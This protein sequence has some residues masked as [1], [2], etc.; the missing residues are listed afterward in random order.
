MQ[1]KFNLKKQIRKNHRAFT[2]LELTVVVVVLA[3]LVGISLPQYRKVV[4]RGRFAEVY[5]IVGII[6][7]AEGRYHLEYDGYTQFPT[8]GCYAG[9]GIAAGSTGVQAA[10]GIEIPSSCYFQYLIYPSDTYPAATNIY[11]RQVGYTWAWVYNYGTK[12]WSVYGA[13]DGGPARE[14]F[15]P[16][17]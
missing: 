6:V 14:Y 12:S 5:N 13:G 2:L 16:P 4:W 3:I 15:V 11:F 7:R 1:E 17:Q 8:G 10:L 9:A